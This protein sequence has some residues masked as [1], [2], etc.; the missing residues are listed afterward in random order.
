M[1]ANENFGGF[2]DASDTSSAKPSDGGGLIQ[3]QT[4]GNL[5]FAQCQLTNRFREEDHHIF[6]CLGGHSVRHFPSESVDQLDAQTGFFVD[7]PQC[8]FF[9]AFACGNVPL[10]YAPCAG[11]VLIENQIFDLAVL[12][13]AVQYAAVGFTT[14]R[15]FFM[16]RSMSKTFLGSASAVYL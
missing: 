2:D 1:L 5:V 8:G 16:Y 10:G 4:V 6:G 3:P 14:A 7:F 11:A 12:T 13:D 9:F 15:C